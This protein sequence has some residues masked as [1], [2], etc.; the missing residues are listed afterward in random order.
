MV[1]ML[2]NLQSKYSELKYVDKQIKVNENV[3]EIKS[4]QSARCTFRP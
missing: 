2:S 1:Q 4:S 3:T